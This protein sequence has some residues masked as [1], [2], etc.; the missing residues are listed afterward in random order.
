MIQSKINKQTNGNTRYT[1]NFDLR[2]C[3]NRWVSHDE[4]VIG[5]LENDATP[6]TN[7]IKTHDTLE[8]QQTKCWKRMIHLKINKQSNEN[9]WYTKK[10][11]L[12]PCKNR[13]VFGVTWRKCDRGS[14]KRCDLTL[15]WGRSTRPLT[16]DLGFGDVRTLRSWSY[17]LG[18]LGLI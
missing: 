9:A 3:K 1:R 8:K 7:I 5:V 11:D 17:W 10:N 13:W 18:N 16:R 2:P 14:R 6:P 12:R 15:S 4:S